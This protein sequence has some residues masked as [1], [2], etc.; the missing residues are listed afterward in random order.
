MKTG[1]GY[2]IIAKI[3]ETTAKHPQ[4]RM[5]LWNLSRVESG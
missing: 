3:V 2:I 5:A 4:T 1:I